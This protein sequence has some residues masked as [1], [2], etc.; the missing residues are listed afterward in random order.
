MADSGLFVILTLKVSPLSYQTEHRTA[1]HSLGK[2]GIDYRDLFRNNNCSSDSPSASFQAQ[3]GACQASAGQDRTNW[4]LQVY[5]CYHHTKHWNWCI[6]FS[7]T[8]E[9][10][11]SG[12]S[13]TC[14][15][16]AEGPVLTDTQICPAKGKD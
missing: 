6:F 11:E 12:Q 9:G 8:T 7:G 13:A 1:V 16:K 2:D 14:L 10:L 3:A 4:V 5:W 15:V